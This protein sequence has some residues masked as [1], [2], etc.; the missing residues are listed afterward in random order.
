MNPNVMNFHKELNELLSMLEKKTRGDSET[1]LVL[2]IQNQLKIA[3]AAGYEE[4]VSGGVDLF[5]AYNDDIQNKNEKLLL[6]GDTSEVL[7]NATPDEKKL[8]GDLIAMI[9]SVYKR[10]GAADKEKAW[11]HLT[12]LRDECFAFSAS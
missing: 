9:R 5:L 2:Q 12:V 3:R 7:K 11:K 10:S 8:Y 6:G 4:I 1:G